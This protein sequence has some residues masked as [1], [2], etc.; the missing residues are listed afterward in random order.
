MVDLSVNE[1]D[2]QLDAIEYHIVNLLLLFNI[3]DLASLQLADPLLG[4]HLLLQP[5][6]HLLLPLELQVRLDFVFRNP[7]LFQ[8]V[9]PPLIHHLLLLL[10]IAVSHRSTLSC[11]LFALR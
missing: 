3:Q 1:L 8:L 10:I 6:G 2:L 4:L 11:K 9:S 7:P 5:L